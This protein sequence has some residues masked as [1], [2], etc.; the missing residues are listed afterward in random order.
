M[1]GLNGDKNYMTRSAHKQ[2]G[3]PTVSHTSP[4]FTLKAQ[5]K[6]QPLMQ[7]KSSTAGPGF[8]TKV[9][10]HSQETSETQRKLK[11]G[12]Q[13][14]TSQNCRGPS[15]TFSLSLSALDQLQGSEL[16]H[17]LCQAQQETAS[18]HLLNT[19]K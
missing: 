8:C 14:P 2:R 11:A 9:W 12:R 13:S 1:V 18:G 3:N 10:N 15:P 19:S 5:Q 16:F 4:Q 17:S 7:S 6:T